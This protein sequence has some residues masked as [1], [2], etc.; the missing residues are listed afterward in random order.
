M[1]SDT[2]NESGA[3]RPVQM[4]RRRGLNPFAPSEIIIMALVI[5]VVLRFCLL[6]IGPRFSF[7]GDHDDYVRYGI[8]ADEEG[9]TSLYLKPPA[10]WPRVA[11]QKDGAAYQTKR[12]TKRVFNYPPLAGYIHWF[13]G[14]VHKLVD[15]DRISN[16]F[17]ARLVFGVVAFLGDLLLAGACF[18][19]V[20]MFASRFVASL[21]CGFA[22]LA[23]PV[24][25]DSAFWGQTDS[26]V[27]APALWM[28]WAMMRQ[29]WW[30]AG[31][32][33]GLALGLKPQALF[34]AAVWLY[35]IITHPRR[36]TIVLAVLVGIL[37]L[38]LL[39]LP[40]WLSSGATWIEKSYVDNLGKHHAKTSLT[41]FN[42]W[43]L[44]QLLCEN[45]S[46]SVEWLGLKKDWWGKIFLGVGVILSYIV[47]RR[48]WR[49]RSEAWLVLS[50]LILLCVVMLVTRVHERYIVIPLP[51]VIALS[52][53]IRRLWPGCILLIAVATAQITAHNWGS[54]L[55]GKRT[56]SRV[57][58][59]YA[60]ELKTVPPELRDQH[61]KQDRNYA[62]YLQLR[63]K[64]WPI[65]WAVAIS[66]MLSF[67]YLMIATATY[68]PAPL[69]ARSPP[70]GE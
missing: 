1:S 35:A 70:D 25:I 15:P 24:M 60:K 7:Y 45:R 62:K 53:R 46:A 36:K 56:R 44:D 17:E 28:V 11:Y 55:A 20:G 38:N 68:R 57:F 19:I 8:Q 42:I 40:F 48:R 34:F 21:A 26:W 14:Q 22:F 30:L 6:L 50:S 69:C 5:G 37:L 2:N 12:R 59:R 3:V 61:R 31:A 18:A 16:T 32:L 65:E 9:V 23:P 33:W 41:A 49:R 10:R 66:A 54:H 58:R 4:A 13:D 47:V 64:D 43:Y 39:A 67:G 29:R 27:I 51:F 52:F 63:S